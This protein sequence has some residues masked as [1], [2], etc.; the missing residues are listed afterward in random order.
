[1]Q[2]LAARGLVIDGSPGWG[3]RAEGLRLECCSAFRLHAKPGRLRV[4]AGSLGV[5]VLFGFVERG[6]VG[7]EAGTGR[8]RLGPGQGFFVH[9]R[10]DLDIEWPLQTLVS[11]VRV[12]LA[13]LADQGAELPLE[14]GRLTAHRSLVAPVNDFVSAVSGA[15]VPSASAARRMDRLLQDM[16]AALALEH[17]ASLP[18]AAREGD[19]YRRAIAVIEA[20]KGDR[21]LTPAAIAET[22]NVS[23]RHLQREFTVHDDGVASALRR[24]RARAA[25]E[26]LADP[27]FAS[28]PTS[29]VA[30]LAGFGSVKSL[31][32]ALADVDP[33]EWSH[34][35][36][37]D[38][39][40]DDLRQRLAD[41][42]TPPAEP[43]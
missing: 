37:S 21:R 14:C 24:L 34:E 31:K 23:L 40:Q 30:E 25:W 2:N 18:C 11:V 5:G 42:A 19:L 26:M 12:P 27:R 13:S 35:T 20:R 16:T 4:G 39:L 7:L 15:D 1:M 43:L 9:A 29:Q 8:D 3:I 22:L 32:R 41:G 28:A 17:K 36:G 33:E 6:L 38:A 10:A